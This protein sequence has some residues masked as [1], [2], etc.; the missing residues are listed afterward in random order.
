MSAESAFFVFSLLDTGSLLFLS[1]Y[2]V[3]GA[4]FAL[5]LFM[6][7]LFAVHPLQ[8][9]TLS[10]LECDYLNASQCC[11]KLNRVRPFP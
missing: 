2:I 7:M 6:L 9:I 4:L 5:I 8:I 10:D 3:S 11:G 1:V